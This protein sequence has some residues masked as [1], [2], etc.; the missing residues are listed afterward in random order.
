MTTPELDSSEARSAIAEAKDE[1]KVEASRR[2]IKLYVPDS[3][4]AAALRFIDKAA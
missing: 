4:N 2:D 3:A 1:L